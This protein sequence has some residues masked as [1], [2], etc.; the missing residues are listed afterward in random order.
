MTAGTTGRATLTWLGS[1]HR[2]P[3]DFVIGGADRPYMRRWYLVPKNTQL[4]VYLHHFRRSD[5]DRALHDHP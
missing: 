1:L 3:P 2:R 4:N 5:D